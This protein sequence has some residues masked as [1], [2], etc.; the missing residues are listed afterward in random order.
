MST[1]AVS[2]ETMEI[3]SKG[4]GKHW[5]AA[6]VDARQQAADKLKRKKKAK[7]APPGWLSDEAREVWKQKLKQVKGLR[8]ANELLDELDTEMLAM[9]CDAYVRYRQTAKIINKTT[10]DIKEL[11]AWARII[12]AYAEKLGFNPSSRARLVKKIAD[13]KPSKF[14]SKFD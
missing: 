13:G 3:G 4:T 6:E 5:T 8:A 2:A 14:G 10:D 9:Y 7:L 1:K 12:G 11:Q